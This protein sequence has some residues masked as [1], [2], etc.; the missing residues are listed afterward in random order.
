M[1]IGDVAADIGL[2]LVAGAAGTAAMTA[3]STLAHRIRGKEPSTAPAEAVE[4]VVRVRPADEQAERRLG[5]A[6]HVAYGVGWGIPRG[7][8]AAAGVA[9]IPASVLHFALVWGAGLTMLPGLD[10]APP[11]N[12]WGLGELALDAT[13]HV[14]Y[15][16]AA[17]AAFAFLADRRTAPRSAP[18]RLGR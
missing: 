16:A 10:I 1:K 9:A 18:A 3:T 14:V 5:T 15:A 7:L 13:H 2:G 11:P 17:G 12:R 6:A 8:L 4:K